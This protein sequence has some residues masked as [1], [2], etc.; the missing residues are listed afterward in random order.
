MASKE[1]ERVRRKADEEAQK[2]MY[3]IC[4]ISTVVLLLFLSCVFCSAA[5]MILKLFGWL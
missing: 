5:F 2:V 1:L 3:G 4:G